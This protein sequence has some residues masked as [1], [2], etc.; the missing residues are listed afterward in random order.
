MTII[1]IVKCTLTYWSHDNGIT[2]KLCSISKVSEPSTVVGVLNL[3]RFKETG[4]Y[5]NYTIHSPIPHGHLVIFDEH[6]LQYTGISEGANKEVHVVIFRH[7]SL[8]V[9]YTVP[10]VRV[11]CFFSVFLIVI[12][13]YFV[14]DYVSHAQLCIQYIRW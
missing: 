13:E 2:T 3:C 8:T 5:Y 6:L 10:A 1:C 7:V 12:V 11:K 4:F 9:L 14:P